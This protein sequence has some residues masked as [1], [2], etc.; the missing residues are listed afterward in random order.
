MSLTRT[1]FAAFFALVNHGSHPYAWQ[2]RLLDHLIAEAAWP[3]TIAAPTGAGKSSVVDIHVFANALSAAGAGPRLPRRLAAVVGR[4]ALVDNQSERARQIKLHLQ[5]GAHPVAVSVREA[6]ASL[7][8]GTADADA[9]YLPITQLRGGLPPTSTWLDEPRACAVINATPDMWGSRLLL[10]GYGS[11]WKAWPREAGLL[12]HDAV[13][14]LDEAHLNRQL[15]FTARTVAHWVA[16]QTEI[17]GVPGLQVVETTATPGEGDLDV[18]GVTS[19]DL[20]ADHALAARMTKPKPI[21]LVESPHMAVRGALDRRHGD[22]LVDLT[23]D[24]RDQHTDRT[25]GCIVNRVDT[26]TYVASRLEKLGYKTGCWVGRMRPMDIQ[27]LRAE[28]PDV[29]DPSLP[30]T[31]DIIVAT[32]TVEVGVDLDLS[33]LVTELAPGSALAQRAGRVNRRGVRPSGPVV[34]VSPPTDAD[35]ELPPYE[36]DD[37]TAARSWLDGLLE[38]GRTLSPWEVAGNPPPAQ[39]PRRGFLKRPEIH[40]A[41]RW[42]ITSTPM[43]ADENLELWLRDSLETEAQPVGIVLRGPLP[44]DDTVALSL[45]VATPPSDQE[46]FPTSIKLAQTAIA[47]VRDGVAGPDPRV[48]LLREDE[49]RQFDADEDVIRPGDVL[50]VSSDSSL[51]RSGV[52]VAG[53]PDRPETVRTIWGS[54][55]RVILPG[56]PSSEWLDDLAGLAAEEAQLRFKDM[57]GSN[58]QLILPPQGLADGTLPWLVLREVEAVNSLEEDRQTWSIRASVALA[59]HSRAVQ[60]R[61]ELLARGL[62][63]SDDLAQV[64]TLAAQHHDDGKDDRRFQLRLGSDGQELLAKSGF[65]SYQELRRAEARTS[66]PTGWRHE[67]RSACHTIEAFTDLPQR[68]LIVRLVGTSHGHG[69]GVPIHGGCDL[70][71]ESE[72]VGLRE[73]AQGLFDEGGWLEL[74]DRTDASYGVWGCAFLEAILRASDCQVSKEGS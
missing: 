12:S 3:K 64:L 27:A 15:L 29:L 45:L 57:T 42:A 1:D 58:E 34:I 54:R 46:V 60:G 66:L 59:Q 11:S 32:Q 30:P 39:Q 37:L 67:H 17:L 74:L 6:L 56:D 4:R 51:T 8:V 72:A 63:I 19:G 65:A 5:E 61:A 9:D 41:M 10:R 40:D 20:A 26:A 16:D 38:A 36:A 35:F 24:M 62:G 43:I 18:I 55:T 73:A 31:L 14:I 25:V 13:L 70:V 33:A 23:R 69:R 44:A 49:V 47:S 50:I 28:H 22:L 48:F 21:T 53:V 2:E 71:G 7:V 52:V 68:E